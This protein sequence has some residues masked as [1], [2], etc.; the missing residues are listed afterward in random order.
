MAE[1]AY[2]GLPENFR[3]A[4]GRIEIHVRDFAEADVLADLGIRDRWE[5]TGLYHGIPLIHDSITFPSPDSP[6]IFLYRQ[7]L[8]AEIRTRPDVTLE[9]LIEHVVTQEEG[10][11]QTK[12]K[13]RTQNRAETR[14]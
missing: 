4:A 11:T 1:A 6:R 7:P 2:A 9:D 8:L 12:I 3:R 5:L 14:T 10:Q 13:N